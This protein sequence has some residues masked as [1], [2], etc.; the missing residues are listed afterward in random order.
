MAGLSSERSRG[1][2][3]GGTIANLLDSGDIMEHNVLGFVVPV[4]AAVLLIGVA[5]QMSGRSRTS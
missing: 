5:E 3:F 2:V 1:S 4:V